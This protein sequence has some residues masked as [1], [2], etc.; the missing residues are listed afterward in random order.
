MVLHIR[1]MFWTENGWPIVSPERFAGTE[2][3]PVTKTEIEGT[4][5]KIKLEYSVTPGF[6]NEQI[7]PDF[8]VASNLILNSN[9]TFDG[10]ASNLWSYTAPWLELNLVHTKKYLSNVEETGRIRKPA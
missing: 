1:K 5:E 10:D 7:T 2:Q 9:G 3:T 8:Q 4:W 6:G